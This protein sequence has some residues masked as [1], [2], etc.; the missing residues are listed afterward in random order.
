MQG[1]QVDALWEADAAAEWERL[2]EPDPCEM[3]MRRAAKVMT[4]AAHSM[5][6]A[7]DKLGEAMAELNGT[8]M[9]AVVGSF[10]DQLEELRAG[11]QQLAGK[12]GKGH[13]E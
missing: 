3:Q 6:V 2:N 4:E 9:E 12:Y 11:L 10:L 5:D 13:R 8:P 1:W 7:E